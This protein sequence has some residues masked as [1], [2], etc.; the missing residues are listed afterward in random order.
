MSQ[1]QVDGTAK[2]P[3]MNQWDL[4]F[5]NCENAEVSAI[6]GFTFDSSKWTSNYAEI[7]AIKDEYYKNYATGTTDIDEVYDE[8][9]EKMYAAG[10][11]DIIDDAQA[12]LDAYLASK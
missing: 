9:M 2:A 12:Q 3:V 4:Y 8:M 10:L 7:T 5:A 6:C 11:Q 1:A